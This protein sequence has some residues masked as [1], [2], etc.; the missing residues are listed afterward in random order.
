MI[1]SPEKDGAMKEPDSVYH[2]DS[3]RIPTDSKMM[4]AKEGHA[5]FTYDP[6]TIDSD[7]EDHIDDTS[8]SD[9]HI[10]SSTVLHSSVVDDLNPGITE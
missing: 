1:P 4:S 9:I 8:E 3:L 2:F 6:P 5:F 10:P 7:G